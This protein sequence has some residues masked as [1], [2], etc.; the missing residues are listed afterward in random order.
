M[1]VS[2]DADLATAKSAYDFVVYDAKKKEFDMGQRR[3]R[4]TLISN[5]A[6][7]CGLAANAMACLTKIY[8]TFK[9]QDVLVLGFPSNEFNNQKPGDEE[10]TIKESCSRFKAD[11]PIMKKIEVNG[12][13][14]SPLY[15]WMKKAKPGF[16]GTESI[17]WNFTFFLLDQ[18]GQVF[19]RF[20]PGPSYDSV[21]KSVLALLKKVP[22][23]KPIDSA[24]S[25]K[26]QEVSKSGQHSVGNDNDD[27]NTANGSRPGFD[28]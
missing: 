22:S 11:F 13:N 21:E 17:K 10:E 28:E 4:P 7:K 24:V 26:E 12:D 8:H 23:Y 14:A 15:K 20:G 3:G 1:P 27:H 16:L 9:D 18:D 5:L 6:M 19:E 2:T 25:M